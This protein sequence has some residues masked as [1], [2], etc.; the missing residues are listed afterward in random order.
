M[1]LREKLH[2]YFVMGSTNCGDQKPIEVLKQALDG[3]V[4]MFQLREKGNACLKGTEKIKFAQEVQSLCQAYDVPFIVNDDVDLALFLEADGVHIGQEDGNAVEVR[5][6]LG[7]RIL[8][9]STHN[10]S[11]AKHAMELGAD[12][13]GIGPMFPTSTK[14]DICEV[15]GTGVIETIRAAGVVMPIVGIGGINETNAS[16]VL[17][18]GA[19]GVAVI[20][21]LSTEPWKA[22]TFFSSGA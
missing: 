20:S 16:Q 10:V 12:Y 22:K 15:K 13:I 5:R 6:K 18:A 7:N 9:V 17:R 8:G 4:T 21:A 3:G 19:D 14:S 1:N 11:E 2:L